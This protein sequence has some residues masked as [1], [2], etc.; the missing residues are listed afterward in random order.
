MRSHLLRMSTTIVTVITTLVFLG[1]V[2]VLLG[3]TE[4]VSVAAPAAATQADVQASVLPAPAALRAI[5]IPFGISDVLTISVDGGQLLATGHAVCWEDGQMF[6]LQVRVAQSTTQAFAVGHSIDIC[7]NGAR[8]L[9]DATAVAQSVAVF[10]PGGARACAEATE[11][12][13]HGIA[14]EHRWCKDIEL[15]QSSGG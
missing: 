13:P 7:A 14:D 11:F 15:A 6:D 8:Q 3:S 2:I 5:S 9:W 10:E 12:G 1:A 4:G